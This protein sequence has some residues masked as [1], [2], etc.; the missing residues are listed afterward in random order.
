MTHP[1]ARDASMCKNVLH[2]YVTCVGA[3]LRVHDWLLSFRLSFFLSVFPSVFPSFLGSVILFLFFGAPH[4]IYL[5]VTSK[6]RIARV[7]EAFPYECNASRMNGSRHVWTCRVL[8]Q[9]LLQATRVRA[10]ARVQTDDNT[11]THAH[12]PTHIHTSTHTNTN[13]G[14]R[15]QNNDNTYTHAHTHT[16]THTHKHKHTHTH[17][18]CSISF[19]RRDGEPAL[20][21]GMTTSIEPGYYEQDHY[22][23]RLE[24]ICLVKPLAGAHKMGNGVELLKFEPLT[25]IPFQVP[26]RHWVSLQD[27]HS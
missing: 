22:G 5:G 25:L 27:A 8:S 3:Y 2:S 11:Q 14:A 17:I 19:R 7:N 12:T 10:G 1:W 9:Y 16:H 24:N 18:H 13:T 21:P 23:I 20:E 6:G 4:S 26:I 15:A